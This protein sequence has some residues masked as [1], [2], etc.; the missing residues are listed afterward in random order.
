MA[1]TFSKSGITTGNTVEAWHV[2]QSIDAF[3]GVEAYDVIL[4]GSFNMTGS[5][6]GEPGVINDLTASY[7]MNAGSASYALT[8]S[9]V[10][11]SGV[12]TNFANTNLTFD[13]NRTHDTSGSS[14]EITT[15]G[16]L[17]NQSWF[18]LDPSELSLG[19]QNSQVF[20]TPGAIGFRTGSNG[21]DLIF[22]LNSS[23]VIVNENSLDIDFRIESN[24]DTHMFFIDGGENRVGI[25]KSTPSSTVDISGSVLITG[26]LSVTQAISA[27]SYQIIGGS[28]GSKSTT[29]PNGISTSTAAWSAITTISAS[30][31]RVTSVEVSIV[32]R[33]VDSPMSGSYAKLAATFLNSGSLSQIG[34]TTRMV[35]HNG[36]PTTDTRIVVSG[37]LISVQA[38]G[39]AGEGITWYT[40]IDKYDLI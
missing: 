12:D 4:S 9:Y 11:G 24:N 36:I 3:S 26:S 10:S 29:S 28:N 37:G 5:I 8:A 7:A 15:D 40:V 34:T 32:G 33:K 6:T 38:Y 22:L 18:Y 16:G 13:G 27:S 39:L 21:N 19:Y 20:F 23:G 35:E 17:Y 30:S 14:L 25:R 31:E 2:T 1:N